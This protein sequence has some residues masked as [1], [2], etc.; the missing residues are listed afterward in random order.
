MRLRGLDVGDIVEMNSASA[1]ASH[2]WVAEPASNFSASAS[3][4]CAEVRTEARL[5]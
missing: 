2:E 1:A 5:P 3:F 4:I